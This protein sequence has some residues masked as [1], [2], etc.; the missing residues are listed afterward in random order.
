MYLGAM[1]ESLPPNRLREMREQAGLKVY[2]IAAMVRRDPSTV[3][4]W[5]RS[6]S[7]VPDQ[8]K[9]QLAAYYNVTAAYLMGWEDEPDGNGRKQKA[10]A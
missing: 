1:P 3:L 5:E 10:A 2:D 6:E 8:I 9:L 7:Q 4:A